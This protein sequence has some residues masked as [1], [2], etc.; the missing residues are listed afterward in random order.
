MNCHFCGKE[1]SHGREMIFVNKKGDILYFCSGKC[2]KN[3]LNLKRKAR[4][5]KWTKAYRDEKAIRKKTAEKGTDAKKKEGKK[6]PVEEKKM[7]GDKNEEPLKGKKADFPQAVKSPEMGT[8][9]S[10]ASD[11]AGKSNEGR[12]EAEVVPED[13]EEDKK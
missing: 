9:S 8:R 7:A 11:K 4:K 10:E 6:R 3:V 1:I 13:G 5:V 12:N 2:E